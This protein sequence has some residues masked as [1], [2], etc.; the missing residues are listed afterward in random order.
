MGFDNFNWF[1]RYLQGKKCPGIAVRPLFHVVT[2]NCEVRTATAKNWK[3]Q[4]NAIARQIVRSS[5]SYMTIFRQHN[6]GHFFT[7]Y[8]PWGFCSGPTR[9]EDIETD[10]KYH[11]CHWTIRVVHGV[12]L[13][14]PFFA[15]T[16]TAHIAKKLYIILMIARMEWL[17]TQR[18]EQTR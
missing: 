3:C 5:A 8:H 12:K 13:F 7:S 2:C 16:V 6:R 18:T 10:S 11:V 17:I 4:M 1:S 15:I 9:I 14:C